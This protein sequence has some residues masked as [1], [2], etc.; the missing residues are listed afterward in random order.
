MSASTLFA[1]TATASPVRKRP[2][3]YDSGDDSDTSSN[4]SAFLE[5]PFKAVKSHTSVIADTAA[6]ESTS[7]PFKAGESGKAEVE[8]HVLATQT[9]NTGAAGAAA[10]AAGAAAGTVS[11]AGEWSSLSTRPAAANADSLADASTEGSG[12]DLA[13]GGVFLSNLMR[14]LTGSENAR[15]NAA[16][17]YPEG[18][19]LVVCELR[20]GA[21]DSI[22]ALL[23]KH[24][25]R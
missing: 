8:E 24:T 15:V 19:E 22:V 12:A 10:G 4:Y 18:S 25:A 2:S 7:D 3:E 6:G 23:G 1:G 13:E 16:F 17:D 11:A 5:D 20:A 9:A 21:G 14:P